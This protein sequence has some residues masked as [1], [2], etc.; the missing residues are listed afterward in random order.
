MSKNKKI[1][2]SEIDANSLSTE[3]IYSEGT[4]FYNQDGRMHYSDGKTS[5]PVIEPGVIFGS[6]AD[7][8]DGYGVN[9]IKLIPHT[10]NGNVEDDRYLIV[11][12]TYPN[13]IHIRAGGTQDQSSADLYLGGEKNYVVVDDSASLVSISSKKQQ[14]VQAIQNINNESNDYILFTDYVADVNNNGWYVEINSQK[15]YIASVSYP[16][17]GQTLIYVPGAPAV[18]GGIYNIF[19]PDL[20]NVWDFNTDGTIYG[21]WGEAAT[22]FTRVE[23]TNNGAGQNVKIGDDA[24]IGDVNMS[25]HIAITGIQDQTE[26]GIIF[27]SALANKIYTGGS[28]MTLEANNGDMNFYMDGAAYIGP[29][30]SENRIAQIKDLNNRVS[31]GM[32]R[33]Q[34]T[35][36]ATGLTFTGSGETYPTYNSYYVKSGNMV[37]FVI[38]V[39]CST[40]T[41]FGTGQYTLELPFA[42]AIGYNH[43]SGWAQVDTNVNPDVTDGHVILNV[44]HAGITSILDLHYLKQAGGAHTPIIEGLF[45]Q[46]TPVTLTTSSK[47]YVNGTYIC[48]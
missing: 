25:N 41:N 6:N 20:T 32:V 10:V 24:W 37:S 35:F 5:E 2:V 39:D 15:Y 23:T 17:E 19:S 47:I 42:P 14:H 40:V 30:S 43:F 3:N 26:G 1:V 16:T 36:A 28:G 46:G 38:E 13:H 7:S 31:P 27:G 4:Y 48:G 33:Y 34:P 22:K 9:T 21:P 11:D 18:I 12:P 45:L 29:S 8:G 44:D